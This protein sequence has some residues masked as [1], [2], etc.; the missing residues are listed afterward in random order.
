MLSLCWFTQSVWFDVWYGWIWL[1]YLIQVHHKRWSGSSK[2]QEVSLR[3]DATLSKFECSYLLHQMSGRVCGCEVYR[4]FR[5]PRRMNRRH[6]K[7]H[8]QAKPNACKQRLRFQGPPG[9]FRWEN[10]CHS[11]WNWLLNWWLWA[12][13]LKGKCVKKF[14]LFT[15]Q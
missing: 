12:I 8:L 1:N 3:W 14:K 9:F 11:T 15:N 7:R 2:S 6:R 4:D 5:H 10:S 13:S